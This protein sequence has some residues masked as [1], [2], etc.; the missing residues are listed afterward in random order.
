LLGTLDD[1]ERQRF[2][3]ATS[4]LAGNQQLDLRLYDDRGQLPRSEIPS[5]VAYLVAGQIVEMFWAR[6]DIFERLFSAP[7]RIWIYSTSQAY[8]RAGGVAGG[9][10]DGREGCVRLLWARI[11]EGFYGPQ[12][13]VSPFLHE[14]GHLLDHFDAQTLRAGPSSGFLPGMRPSDGAIYTPAARAAF[15]RG[16]QL[17]LERSRRFVAGAR[18]GDTP[19]IGHPYVLQ[20][21]TEF[22]A[23]YLEMFFRNPHA[24][25]EQNRDLFDGFALLFKHDPRS[26][27]DEDF[28]KYVRENRAFYTSGQRPPQPGITVAQV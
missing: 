23:G 12:P 8:S 14:W 16:K 5:D 2:R 18:P 6:P 4:A 22:I 3:A 19:P 24:F 28:P 25:A 7:Q 13:E 26:W 10:Y 27:R 15:L 11:Y 17:E 20:N 1:A 9:C 21:N